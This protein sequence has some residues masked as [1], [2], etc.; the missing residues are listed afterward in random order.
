M[1]ALFR[2]DEE[3]GKEKGP[4]AFLLDNLLLYALNKIV[5]RGRES[6]SLKKKKKE[7]SYNYLGRMQRWPNFFFPFPI[8]SILCFA[9]S[10]LESLATS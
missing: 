2:K 3:E 7:K 4:K 9:E 5:Y 8:F 1:A 6:F 10:G